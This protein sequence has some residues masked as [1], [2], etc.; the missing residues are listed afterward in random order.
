MY[1]RSHTKMVHEGKYV[2]EVEVKLINTADD[3]KLDT[4]REALKQGDIIMAK[5]Y[6]KVYKL[7][8]VAA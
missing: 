7:S 2:A 3:V 1:S 8:E 6:S 4:V 5:K